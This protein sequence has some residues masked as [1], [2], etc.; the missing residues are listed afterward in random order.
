MRTSRRSP[1]T[2]PA[3]T[4]AC[5]V[6]Q[7]YRAPRRHEEHEDTRRKTKRQ[8]VSSRFASGSEIR[9]RSV[10]RLPKILFAH[11]ANFQILL[12]AARLKPTSHHE[13]TRR[14]AR[15]RRAEM[16]EICIGDRIEV[17][18]NMDQPRYTAC[19]PQLAHHCARTI[20]CSLR[21]PFVFFVSY[22]LSALAVSWQPGT[23]G[24]E[25]MLILCRRALTLSRR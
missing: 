20:S 2:P 9:Q 16:R 1:R 14:K 6:S 21:A 3:S 24:A 5:R 13:D 12:I 8:G 23:P 18:V 19:Q 4:E 17:D 22:M 11:T 10:N 7:D 15:A 25:G